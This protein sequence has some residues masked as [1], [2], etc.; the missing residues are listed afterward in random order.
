MKLYLM[1]HCESEDGPRED[2]TRQLTSVGR[3]QAQ[4]MGQFLVRQVGRVDVVL[5][6]YFARAQGTAAP[7][8]EL[9]GCANIIDTPALQPDTEPKDAWKEIEF[10]SDGCEEVLVV[11]HH[12][13]TNE[14]LK[15]LTGCGAEKFHHG[16]IAHIGEDGLLHWFVP[17]AVVERD[18]NV[19]DA[20]A[21]VVEALYEHLQEAKAE[22]GLKHPR[23]QAVLGKAQNKLKTLM[24]AYFKKQGAAVLKSVKPNIQSV[25]KQYA[26]TRNTGKRFASSLVPTS[27]QPL[28]FPITDDEDTKYQ[29][30]ITSAIKGAAATLAKELETDATLSE[31]AASDYLRDNSLAKLTGDFTGETLDRLRDALADAW[32][33]GGGFNAMVDAVQDTFEDFSDTRAEMIAQTEANDAY[34]EGRSALAEEA[35]MDEKSWETE[36][37]DPCQDCIDNEGDGWIDIDDTFSSGDLAPTA[38]PNCACSLNFRM[39]AQS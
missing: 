18:E 21:A 22:T 3:Q 31:D 7:I 24:A 17:P 35:G 5:T 29:S 14:L 15:L 37:G 8:A 6:S 25:L 28:S 36:S 19:I 13:L 30:I 11:T 32:D 26:E 38:H 33:K 10:L 27:L 23:H 20:A 12:P 16:A 1:R 39:G 4:T 2:P 34:N 9:L